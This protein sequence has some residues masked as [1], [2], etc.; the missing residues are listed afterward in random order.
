MADIAL[1]GYG[2]LQRFKE[3]YNSKLKISP[4]GVIVTIVLIAVVLV[5][6]NWY[7]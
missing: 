6:L 1:P 3:E 2:G 4:S 5:G 7:F